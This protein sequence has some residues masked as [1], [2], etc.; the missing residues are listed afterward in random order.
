MTG[1]VSLVSMINCNLG[2]KLAPPE[3]TLMLHKGDHMQNDP[4]VM[5][6]DYLL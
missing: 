1:P 2:G 5:C 3:T 6:Q 4:V